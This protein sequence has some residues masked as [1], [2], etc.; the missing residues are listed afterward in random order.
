MSVGFYG[1]KFLPL[2]RGHIDCIIEASNK[3]DMLYVVLSYSNIRDK[4]LC[5]NSKI[6]YISYKKRLDWLNQIAN[7]LPNVKVITIED[8]DDENYTSWEDGANKVKLQINKKIDFVFGSEKEYKEIFERLYPDSKY[9]LLNHNRSNFPISATKIREEGVFKY[10]DF[11]PDICKPYYNKKVVI[12][13]SESSGKSTMVKKLALHYNTEY[14]EEYGRIMCEKLNTG[15]PPKEYY[16]YIAYGHKMLEFEK[17]QNANKILFID[18]ESTVTQFYNELYTDNNLKVL[19]EISKLNDYD[20]V[21]FLEANVKW[22]DDGLRI[23]NMDSDRIKND[24]RLKKLLTKNNIKFIVVNDL[25]YEGRYNNVKILI[26]NLIR[27]E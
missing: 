23:H 21:I 16:Q 9:I 20:L 13:G 22:V 4:S 2:H 6:K 10:W 24:N 14:V 26:D 27:G 25:S 7:N 15:Q 17:L 1:G 12:V 5:E 8:F 18:T 11:I 3:C 19:D